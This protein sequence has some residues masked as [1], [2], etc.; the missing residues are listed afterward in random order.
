M[1]DEYRQLLLAR[2]KR[3]PRRAPTPRSKTPPRRASTRGRNEYEAVWVDPTLKLTPKILMKMSR[4]RARKRRDSGACRNPAPSSQPS[5]RAHQRR[6]WRSVSLSFARLTDIAKPLCYDRR[7]SDAGLPALEVIK[8]TVVGDNGPA[9]FVSMSRFN[10]VS[11][12]LFVT[13]AGLG[14]RAKWLLAAVIGLF[15]ASLFMNTALF[16]RRIWIG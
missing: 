15:G 8:L 12:P 6:A 2:R 1:V 14:L 10:L 7:I 13:L 16:A 4:R 5:G 11:F 3:R 9:G